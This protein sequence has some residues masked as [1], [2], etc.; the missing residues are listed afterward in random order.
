LGESDPATLALA[1][2]LVS[3]AVI[4]AVTALFPSFGRRRREAASL[5]AI[6]FVRSSFSARK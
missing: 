3:I 6:D 4:T 1:G 2:I 5:T